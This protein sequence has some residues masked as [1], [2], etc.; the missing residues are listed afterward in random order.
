MIVSG[1]CR[2]RP[3]TGSKQWRS[4]DLHMGCIDRIRDLRARV[5]Q[6]LTSEGGAD[7]HPDRQR[8]HGGSE[9]LRRGRTSYCEHGTGAHNKRG[10]RSEPQW[11]SV[12]YADVELSLHEPTV[13]QRVD[14]LS[15]PLGE[16]GRRANRQRARMPVGDRQAIIVN[17]VDEGHHGRIE[18]GRIDTIPASTRT[19]LGAYIGSASIPLTLSIRQ[20]SPPLHNTP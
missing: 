18:T 11:W 16:A 3:E 13:E 15:E 14:A 7:L 1:Q 4:V 17:T 10:V 12:V 2:E 19:N 8:K 20:C 9:I 5:R 6:L